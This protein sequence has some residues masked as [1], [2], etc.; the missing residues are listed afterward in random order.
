MSQLT[1][2]L[3]IHHM[4]SPMLVPQT[5][6]PHAGCPELYSHRGRRRGREE[7]RRRRRRRERG[8]RQ[9]QRAPQAPRERQAGAANDERDGDGDGA[10]E[11]MS[12]GLKAAAAGWVLFWGFSLFV[13]AD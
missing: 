13:W 12:C 8:L 9:W 3:F 4:P 7:K 6:V 2:T 10:M 5:L 11:R 1:P